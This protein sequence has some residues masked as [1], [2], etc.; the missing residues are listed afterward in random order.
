MTQRQSVTS[1][2]P[3]SPHSE[4]DGADRPDSR[5]KDH[6][7]AA[8]AAQAPVDHLL[9]EMPRNEMGKVQT[10]RSAVNHGL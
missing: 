2:V 1:P 6:V 9:D 8:H 7:G 5:N 3:G 10:R 4:V